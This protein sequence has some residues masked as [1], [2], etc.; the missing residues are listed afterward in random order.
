MIEDDAPEWMQ[1]AVS[2]NVGY[3]GWGPGNDYMKGSGSGWDSPIEAEASEDLINPDDLNEIVSYY[4]T[5]SKD[6]KHCEECGGSGYSKEANALSEF[7]STWQYQL[8][9]DEA[10][11]LVDAERVFDTP[12]PN[13]IWTDKGWVKNEDF[14]VDQN[15]LDWLNDKPN[16]KKNLNLHDGINRHILVQTRANR[17]YGEDTCRACEGH[18]Y[19]YVS[20]YKLKLTCWL[21]HPRKGASR[22]YTINNIQESDMPKMLV[23]LNE[24]RMQNIQRFGNLPS[25]DTTE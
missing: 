19:T 2:Y 12:T 17:L 11:A 16:R 13:K 6:S 25:I 23:F 10:Q 14:K 22:A 24:V 7:F 1:K 8:T 15:F 4:F 18:G 9:M 5:A 20:D 3:T 21:L